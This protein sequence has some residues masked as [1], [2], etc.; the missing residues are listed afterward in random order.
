MFYQLGLKQFGNFARLKL[1]PPAPLRALITL[2]VDAEQNTELSKLS[3]PQIVDVREQSQNKRT[4]IFPHLPFMQSITY[5]LISRRDMLREYFSLGITTEGMVDS[6][7]MLV[8][9]LTPNLDKLPL[10]FMRLGPQVSLFSAFNLVGRSRFLAN[11]KVNW[12]NEQDC[13]DTFLR[14]LAY[15][16]VPGP[17]PLLVPSPPGHTGNDDADKDKDDHAVNVQQQEEASST[18]KWQ[19]EHIL[20]PAMKRYLVAP[21]SLLAR[22][23]VQIASLPDL[24]RVFER[25]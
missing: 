9:D 13:F 21:K 12:N 15:F 22:D 23:V 10:F 7:P 2:A 8:P 20:F 1:D 4:R 25:C 24:Y 3:K 6:L 11:V 19:I 18:E 5:I 14:E 16:Y 17:G